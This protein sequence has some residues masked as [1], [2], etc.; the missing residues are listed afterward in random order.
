MTSFPR[1]RESRTMRRRNYAKDS[2]DS[3]YVSGLGKRG[4]EPKSNLSRG[5]ER[6]HPLPTDER[7]LRTLERGA[8][9]KEQ[10]E[11]VR[12]QEAA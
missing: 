8:R 3:Q 5:M 4:Q 9:R 1:K 10:G 11:S 6:E 2:L 12:V 7:Q